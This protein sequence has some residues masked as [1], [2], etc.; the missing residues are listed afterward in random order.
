MVLVVAELEYVQG[1]YI[2]QYSAVRSFKLA[3]E[4]CERRLSE[5]MM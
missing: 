5:E 2:V 3:F 4:E 1:P